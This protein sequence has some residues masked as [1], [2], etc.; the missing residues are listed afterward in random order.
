VETVAS[1]RKIIRTV[2]KDAIEYRLIESRIYSERVSG[3]VK[4]YSVEAWHDERKI[5]NADS[6]MK[7]RAWG[8]NDLQQ[9]HGGGDIL[10][11]HG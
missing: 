10:P 4:E 11:L 6:D 2:A 8:V 3:V 5:G 9:Y 1:D 7:N